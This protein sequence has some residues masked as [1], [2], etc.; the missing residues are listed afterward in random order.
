MTVKPSI[1]LSD[2][3][4]AFARKL[5]EEGRFDSIDDV[6]G[7]SLDLL[8]QHL[9]GDGGVPERLEALLQRRRQ[10]AFVEAEDF[11]RRLDVMIA[12]KRRANGVSA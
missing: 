10:G 8:R 5:V 7:L 9:A 1:P 2:E 6:V 3:Q 11:D 4:F 12:A